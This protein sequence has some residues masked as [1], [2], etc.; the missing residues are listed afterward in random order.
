MSFASIKANPRRAPPDPD[1]GQC[2]HSA[3]TAADSSRRGDRARADARVQTPL[4]GPRRPRVRRRLHA[5][6]RTARRRGADRRRRLRRGGAA[7]LEV[8]PRG[9]DGR[10]CRGAR[11]TAGLDRGHGDPVRARRVGRAPAPPSRTRRRRRE[12]PPGRARVGGGGLERQPARAG[13]LDLARGPGEERRDSDGRRSGRALAAPAAPRAGT[14]RRHGHGDARRTHPGARAVADGDDRRRLLPHARAHR[15]HRG[16]P[17]CDARR[18]ARSRGRRGHS[19]PRGFTP[20]LGA[21]RRRARGRQDDADRRGAPAP[22]RRVVRVPGRRRGRERRPDVHRH[23]RGPRARHRLPPRAAAD[24]MDLPQLRGI[25]LVRPA[26]AEPARPAGRA[27]AAR[28]G[29]RRDCRRRDRP[30]RVRAPAPAPAA[31]GAAVRGGQ[32]GA[33]GPAGHDGSGARLGGR[34][35][36]RGRRRH[37]GRSARSRNALPADGGRAGQRPARPRARPGP[38]RARRGRGGRPGDGD[39][40]P[41]RRH[42]AA[43]PR[44]RPAGAAPASTSCASTSPRACSASPRRSSA[45]STGS[46]S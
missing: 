33:D 10:D 11:A 40:D 1:G 35:R 34:P 46:R 24:R 25:A 26:H 27:A 3:Q 31:A 5:A 20:A 29:R 14:D 19:R 4:G 39:R 9:G 28:G 38:H 7:G 6:R 45:S 32:A 15:G 21:A 8:P 42:R 23:A 41:E 36:A 2:A 16:P 37:P 30:A 12:D 43:A 44:A 18:L 17:A 13:D 22:R